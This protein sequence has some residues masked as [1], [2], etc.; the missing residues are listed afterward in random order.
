MTEKSVLKKANSNKGLTEEIAT[1]KRALNFYSLAN[2]LPDPDIVLRKQGKDI[3]IYKELLCDPHVFACTQ[4]RKAGVLSLDWEINRGIDKDKNSEEIINLLRKLNINKLMS[5]ILDATQFGYQPLEI[6]WEK[7]KSGH[8]LPAKIIAK[9]PEWFCFDDDNNLKFRTKENYYGEIVPDKKFLLAQNNPSYNNP[10]GER[11]LSR[12]F[13]AVTFKKGGLKFWVVFTEKYGMPHLIGKHPR[14]A[15][16]DETETLADMLEDMVQD[17][18]AVIPDDSSV[19]IQEANKSSSAEIYEKLIDKMNSE[20]SKAV[21][22]QTLTTEI[23]STGSYAAANTHMAVR[24]D[25]IDAD[26]KLVE[27][28][29]NQLIR[30]IYE[31]NYSTEEIPVFEMYAPED[32]DLSL[33]QRDKILSETGVKFTKE[34]FIKNYGLENEDFDIREDFYPVQTPNFKEFQEQEDEPNDN[35]PLGQTQLEELFKFISE[36]E[37]T[38]QAQNLLNP[39]ISLIETCDSYEDLENVL[40]EKNLKSK[41]FEQDLQKALFLCELQGRSD[42]LDD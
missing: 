15:T 40:K 12:C 25:I 9:P 18:I 36:T 20:I 42:G 1:R 39:I 28:V 22:G 14:G 35:A 26:R 34:Y 21:L 37:L 17:A 2:I 23:G 38:S 11:T 13:W 32:V 16:K 3:K 8:I 33:A 30:W 27:S 31:I 19:E 29:I 5:D 41:K 6:I 4:S 7:S 10:Y 24:Q